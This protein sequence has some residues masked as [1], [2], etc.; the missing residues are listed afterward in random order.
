MKE[1]FDLLD[2]KERRILALICILLSASLIFHTAFAL[3]EKKTY[4]RSVES[5]PSQQREYEKIWEQNQKLKAELLRWDEARREIPQIEKVYFYREEDVANEVRLDLRKI[6]Q[7]S[8][9][10]R[11]RIESG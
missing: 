8:K 5:L 2:V 7:V 4:F 9:K 6:F 1:L 11:K 10:K 3:H